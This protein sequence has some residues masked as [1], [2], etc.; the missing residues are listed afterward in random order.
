MALS[1]FGRMLSVGAI[2][3][4]DRI[5][6]SK[7]GKIGGDRQVSARGAVHTAAALAG[8]RKA[9]VSTGWTISHLVS[10][11]RLRNHSPG[12]HFWTCRQHS[13]RWSTRWSES[14]DHES[15]LMSGCG[16]G[17]EPKAIMSKKL[18]SSFQC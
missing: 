15:S 2:R 17:H 13:V 18:S 16:W 9:L 4:E 3:F 5:C 11:N 6:T 14:P 8:C 10:T 1:D 7:K 12:H